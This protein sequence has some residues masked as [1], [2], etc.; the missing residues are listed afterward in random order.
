MDIKNLQQQCRK[1]NVT[2]ERQIFDVVIIPREKI[3]YL[4]FGFSERTKQTLLPMKLLQIMV[5]QNVYMHR[6]TYHH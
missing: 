5:F 2:S 3:M 6:S 4:I 1:V